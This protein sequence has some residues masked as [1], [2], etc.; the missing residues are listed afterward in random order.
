MILKINGTEYEGEARVTEKTVDVMITAKMS[1]AF[2]WDAPIAVTVN[3]VEYSVNGLQMLTQ[4][5]DRIQVAW[6]RESDA[7]NLE[8]Q[9]TEAQTE[10]TESNSR[11]DA[12]REAIKDLG[13][14]I[15]TLTKLTA[16][17]SAVKE[18]IHYDD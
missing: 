16:F 18:A 4:N 17:L 12:I 10:L 6:H 2:A 9:L 11:L 14:G 13:T 1:D 15:P 3:G 8:R 5:G 7:E